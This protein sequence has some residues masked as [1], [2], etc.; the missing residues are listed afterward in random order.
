MNSDAEKKLR[1]INAIKKILMVLICILVL[2]FGLTTYE[3]YRVKLGKKPVIC[4]GNKKD[5]ENEN[6]YSK[7]CYGLFY[8]YKEYYLESD[9]SMS[10]RE[11]ALFFMEWERNAERSANKK[12]K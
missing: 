3:Y 4:I 10:A 6:E 5:I 8:K 2:W 9:D 11:F 12:I 1:R 7:M